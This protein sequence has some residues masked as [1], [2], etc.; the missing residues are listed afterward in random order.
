MRSCVVCA[1]TY[2][3]FAHQYNAF[4]GMEMRNPCPPVKPSVSIA[5]GSAG[6]DGPVINCV[7]PDY[8]TE[9]ADPL[10]Y[11]RSYMRVPRGQSVTRASNAL[12]R[13]RWLSEE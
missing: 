1:T 5:N 3:Y 8:V 10:Y 11:I 6:L 9:D 13:V 2:L 12:V 4:S 7:S